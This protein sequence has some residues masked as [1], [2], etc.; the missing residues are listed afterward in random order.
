MNSINH[1]QHPLVT[2]G[3][4]TYNRA[5]G[6]LNQALDSAVKQT[7]A[8]IEIIVSDNCSTDNTE[9]VV[10]SFND[11]RIRYFKQKENIGPY[12]NVAFCLNM[13]VGDYFMQLHDDDLID[14][15]FVETCMKAAN[16]SKDIG[17]IR[18]GT[19]TIDSGN[20]T[21]SKFTN[22]A[23]GLSTTE[24]FRSWF[25]CKT[26]IYLC[27]TLYNTQ[28][29][30]EIGGF[31]TNFFDD[32]V[33]IVQL[34][35]FGRVD[36]EEVKAST[37]IHEGEITFSADIGEW[38]KD[39][40]YVLDLMC[41]LVNDQEKEMFREEGVKFLSNINYGF[42]SK[43]KAPVKRYSSYLSVFKL[44]NYKH[45]PPAL[46]SDLYRNPV[47]SGL[48]FIKDKIISVRV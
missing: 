38:C 3:I 16:Y 17:I 12:K 7:Y 26:S 21:L 19:R 1:N 33:A 2:L 44:F 15:D 45:L 36:V 23:A 31:Q 4:P 13:A 14:P 41:E 10:S 27:S 29:L 34:A 24:F 30:K 20:N 8:N 32:V 6:Y 42:A 39:S 25:R 46:K 43:V 40:L 11:S 47:Y 18:T 9:S 22:G 35:K 28:K 5:D 37:R 48:R